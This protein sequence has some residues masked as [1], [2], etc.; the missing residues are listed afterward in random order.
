M[1]QL[2]TYTLRIVKRGKF[3]FTEREM[4]LKGE[5]QRRKQAQLIPSTHPRAGR[6][7]E[8][9][10]RCVTPTDVSAWGTLSHTQKKPK[11]LKYSAFRVF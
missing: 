3:I 1:Y 11:G 10:E 4:V 7:E 2:V 5:L 9:P 6:R 8:T